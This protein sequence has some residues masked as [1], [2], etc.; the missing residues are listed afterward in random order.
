MIERLL[1]VPAC[2]ALLVPLLTSAAE[3]ETGSVPATEPQTEV[4]QKTPEAVT[5]RPPTAR[6][7]TVGD[8]PVSPHQGQVTE[9]AGARFGYLDVDKDGHISA[10]ESQADPALNSQW[11]SLDRNSDDRLDRSEFARFEP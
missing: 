1:P 2:A 11:K 10:S 5:E 4:L 6:G 3:V 8:M 9:E 7:M